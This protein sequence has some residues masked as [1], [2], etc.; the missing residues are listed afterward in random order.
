MMLRRE[1]VPPPPDRTTLARWILFTLL[2][3]TFPVIVI[4]AIVQ[5]TR[6]DDRRADEIRALRT[7]HVPFDTTALGRG[8]LQYN[9]QG[10]DS[11]A[12]G[13]EALKA[14]ANAVTVD[15][16]TL[17]P[18][19]LNIILGSTN[20]SGGITAQDVTLYMQPNG[21]AQYIPLGDK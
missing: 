18:E 7:P 14:K 2:V 20:Q 1:I 15:G 19:A 4:G 5:H 3:T 13:T 21:S 11:I 10:H 6:A 9:T 16:K 12:I 17:T 8:A